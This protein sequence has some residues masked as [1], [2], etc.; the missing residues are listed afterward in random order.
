MFNVYAF[1]T[2]ICTRILKKKACLFLFYDV[3][4]QL[5]YEN[6]TSPSKVCVELGL[7]KTA[8]SFWKRTNGIPKRETL[9]K[10]AER[11]N[12]SVDYLLGKEKEKPAP[13]QVNRNE[14]FSILAQLTDSELDDLLKYSEFLLSKR[15]FQDAQDSQ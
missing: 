7:S 14:L 12:V 2:R 8:S 9:E 13:V 6:R 11:F 15:Q 5:C 10:I 1:N 3:F 4:E